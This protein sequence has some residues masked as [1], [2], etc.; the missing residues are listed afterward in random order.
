[1]PG[2]FAPR[3]Q[4]WIWGLGSSMSWSL[5]SGAVNWISL[6][7][8]TML[9]VQATA[10]M[11]KAGI[12]IDTTARKGNA[13]AL[14]ELSLKYIASLRSVDR[15]ILKVRVSGSSAA[16]LFL[17]HEILKLPNHEVLPILPHLDMIR[18]FG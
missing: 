4:R 9:F 2:W 18:L 13:L 1:M 14:S 5:R 15:S 6:A 7:L 12:N 11:E 16:R 8:S 17:D 10:S 3:R